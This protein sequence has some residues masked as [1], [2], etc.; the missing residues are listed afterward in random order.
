VF[1]KVLPVV[2]QVK[3]WKFCPSMRTSPVFTV[4]S[5]PGLPAGE[6]VTVYLVPG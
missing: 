2:L 6:Y 1:V 5:L 4:G 3:S